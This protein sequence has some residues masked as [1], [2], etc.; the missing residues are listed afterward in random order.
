MSFL[1]EL[2][3]SIQ[4]L[5]S[6]DI[7][8]DR[9]REYIERHFYVR[10]RRGS[11]L[12]PFRFN[13]IQERY[14]T[15]RTKSD[16]ILK[17][18]QGGFSTI[19][20]AEYFAR[21]CLVPNETVVIL[22][23]RAESTERLFHTVHLFYEKLP[24]SEKIRV[25]G[26]KKSARVKSK[27]ELYLEG[28]NSRFLVATAGSP[29]AV[30]SLSITSA[31]LSEFSFWPQ[32][33]AEDTLSA[34]LG[35]LVPDGRVRIETT[36]NLAGSF[37]Y[38]LWRQSVSGES[39]FNPVFLPWWEDPRNRLEE[40]VPEREW[41]EEERHLAEAHGLDGRQIAWRRSMVLQQKGKFAREYPEDSEQC[42][43]QSGGT[44]FDM[45][46]VLEAW[47]RSRGDPTT[48]SIDA[49]SPGERWFVTPD[50][51]VRRLREGHE[52]VVGADPAS[53]AEDG[54]Y[55]AVQAFDRNGEQVYAAHVRIPVYQFADLLARVGHTLG[56]ALLV[57][58]RNNHGHAV[59][60]RLVMELGYP[61]IY[62]DTRHRRSDDRAGI[63]TNQVTKTEMIS[64]LDRALWEGGIVLRDAATFD[65]L[66]TYV[67]DERRKAG[68]APGAHDDLVSALLC[69]NLALAEDRSLPP[70]LVEVEATRP[71]P[72]PEREAGGTASEPV[73]WVRSEGALL[74]FGPAVQVPSP[75]PP[76][77][78]LGALWTCGVCGGHEVAQMGMDVRCAACG[79][80]ASLAD[81]MGKRLAAMAFSGAWR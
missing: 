24:E 69:A 60:Q 5:D 32:D 2:K 31:H 58:E 8:D 4:R 12:V 54:D 10:P 29:D 21:C 17:Y 38:Q 74:P 70:R 62:Y 51:L 34:I 7:E 55:S 26:G 53:G 47:D 44:V 57:V 81:V 40:A 27:H 15:R 45:Q 72:E 22:A 59:L 64:L 35:A 20:M 1:A 14:W 78:A 77:L 52:F 23:H 6:A 41:T 49:L 76:E 68:A 50:D 48:A 63:L 3:E 42:W 75:V 79:A 66:R 16:Y 71:K 80:P 56:D 9:I 39:R 46:K 18:R 36:P 73:A 28:M 37:A 19:T 33:K 43:T 11:A 30:R 61:S 67:W 13:E 25:N 65:Q